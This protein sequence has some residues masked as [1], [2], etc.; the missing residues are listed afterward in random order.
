MEPDPRHSRR[1]PR[2]L[3]PSFRGKAH[4][5][6]AAG[7]DASEMAVISVAHEVEYGRHWRVALLGTPSPAM[8]LNVRRRASSSVNCSGGDF[9]K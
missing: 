2:R 4:T 8:K 6:S 5:G 7:Q 1:E 9:M 3:T